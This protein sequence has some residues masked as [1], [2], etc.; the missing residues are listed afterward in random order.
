L[1]HIGQHAGQDGKR[2]ESRVHNVSCVFMKE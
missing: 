1:R 2:I